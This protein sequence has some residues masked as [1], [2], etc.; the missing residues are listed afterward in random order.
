MIRH[1]CFVISLFV[2]SACSAQR[3]PGPAERIGRSIDEIRRS[4]EELAPEETPE[5]RRVREDREWKRRQDDY[6]RRNPSK[7]RYPYESEREEDERA[8]RD[9]EYWENPIGDSGRSGTADDDR[10]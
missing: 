3:E 4:I 8:R 10:Y 5:Q 9:R 1:V 6:Y 7:S 2:L